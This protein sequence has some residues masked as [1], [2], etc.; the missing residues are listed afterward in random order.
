LYKKEKN[1]DLVHLANEEHDYGPSKRKALYSFMAKHLRLNLKAVTGSAGEIDESA[2]KV[3][4]QRE[5]EVFNEA[6]PRPANAVMGDAEVLKLL[7]R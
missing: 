7:D 4:D 5:L 1:V 6:H 2:A 3:L